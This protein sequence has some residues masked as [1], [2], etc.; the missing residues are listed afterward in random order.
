VVALCNSVDDI[1][2]DVVEHIAIFVGWWISHINPDESL[3]LL[4]SIHKSLTGKCD[5][6]T[7]LLGPLSLLWGPRLNSWSA[8]SEFGTR[9]API[10]NLSGRIKSGIA[11]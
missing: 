1:R 11:S 4:L 10:S 8:H 9:V 2:L 5:S 7:L 6:D 3:Y